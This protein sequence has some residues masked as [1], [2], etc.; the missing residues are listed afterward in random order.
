M[1]FELITYP[2]ESGVQKVHIVDNPTN[3]PVPETS[4][5]TTSSQKQSEPHQK[6]FSSQLQT[7]VTLPQSPPS[8]QVGMPSLSQTR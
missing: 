5:T 8:S 2:R 3:V 1:T 4:Q 6:Q 7:P